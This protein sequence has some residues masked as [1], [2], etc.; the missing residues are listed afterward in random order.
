M[1]PIDWAVQVYGGNRRLHCTLEPSH[2][3]AF[4]TGL[5]L[6]LIAAVASANLVLPVNSR[7][8]RLLAATYSV[9]PLFN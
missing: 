2:G 4:G 7:A 6:G 3:W 1:V 8:A 9:I 5:R